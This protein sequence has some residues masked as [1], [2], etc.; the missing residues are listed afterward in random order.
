[1]SS[2]IRRFGWGSLLISILLASPSK[3]H[4]ALI[5]IPLG[6]F[7][8]TATVAD[9]TVAA[10]QRLP[11][12]EDGATFASFSGLLASVLSGNNFLSMAG[13]GVLDVTFSTPVTRAGFQVF[14]SIFPLQI[15]VEAFADLQGTQ[16]VGQIPLGTFT[17]NQ[18][19]FTGFEATALFSRVSIGFTPQPQTAS[20][21]IDD[22][23]FERS[24]LAVPEPATLAMMLIGA[25]WLVGRMRRTV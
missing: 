22:F 5:Q 1:V 18:L 15:S 13:T 11:Y 14:P 4:A 9:F 2:H 3:S 16:S 19:S 12:S 24:S 20:F 8:G 7:S 6:G 21:F 25:G 10:T 23:R 17:A